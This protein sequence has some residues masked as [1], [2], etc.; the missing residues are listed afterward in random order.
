MLRVLLRLFAQRWGLCRLDGPLLPFA[1]PAPR[2]FLRTGQDT[3]ATDGMNQPPQFG[4]QPAPEPCC[5]GKRAEDVA[6]QAATPCPREECGPRPR[7]PRPALLPPSLGH[8]PCS[9][10]RGPLDGRR[11]SVVGRVLAC[12]QMLPPGPDQQAFC[13]QRQARSSGRNLL[14]TR[15]GVAGVRLEPSRRTIAAHR[16]LNDTRC[17]DI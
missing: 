6:H 7:L 2:A 11:Q 4:F 13:T 3:R 5:L 16:S 10:Y 1:A 15:S 17:A 8:R 14:P 12:A 9:L